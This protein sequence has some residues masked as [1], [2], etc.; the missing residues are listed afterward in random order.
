MAALR[1]LGVQAA[2]VQADASSVTYGKDIVDGTLAAFP[3]RTI[4]VLVNNAG[5]IA[6]F[7]SLAETQVEAFTTIFN[8]NVRSIFLLIQ[9]A[10]K[11]LTTPGARI[12]NISSVG[13]R[14]GIAA[15]GFYSVRSPLSVEILL[16]M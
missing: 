8:V 16:K 9:A 13:A 10:E 2:A 6:A 15:A 4:D 14:I 5:T 1:A 3:G 7:P 11:H 12:V